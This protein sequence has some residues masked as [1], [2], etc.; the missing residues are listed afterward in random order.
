MRRKSKARVWKISALPVNSLFPAPHACPHKVI[1]EL[2]QAHCE[3]K[4]LYLNHQEHYC[5]VMR[6][7]AWT[8]NHQEHYCLVM[9]PIA[10]TE[11]E[12]AYNRLF[13][14]AR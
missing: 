8:E 4:H 9:R 6:P 10:W 1:R 12:S 5:L 14:N 2:V 7:I 3:S 13:H 11:N